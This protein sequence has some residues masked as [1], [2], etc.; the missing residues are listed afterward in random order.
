M[1]STLKSDYDFMF[2]MLQGCMKVIKSYVTTPAKD[3]KY[4]FLLISF[5]LAWESFCAL[6]KSVKIFSPA[7]SIFKEKKSSD[8]G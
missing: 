2:Q 5:A 3:I 4:F 1:V 8:S 6:E 7:F